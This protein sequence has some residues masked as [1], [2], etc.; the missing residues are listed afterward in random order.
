MPARR[1]LQCGSIYFIVYC[2]LGGNAAVAQLPPAKVRFPVRLDVSGPAVVP[3]TSRYD[4]TSNC[5]VDADWTIGAPG[6][7]TT[8]KAKKLT[9]TWG[10]G[11][12]QTTIDVVCGKLTKKIPVDVVEVEIDK[13]VVV[14][15]GRASVRV[16]PPLKVVDTDGSTAAIKFTVDVTVTGPTRSPQWGGKIT[17]GFVQRLITAE[18]KQWTAEYSLAKKQSSLHADTVADPPPKADCVGA[19][20][21]C[22]SWYSS[23]NS[24]IYA[25]T[26]NVAP[27]KISIN[28][29]PAPGWWLKDQKKTGLLLREAHA[30]WQ[31][32]TY[33]CVKSEDKFAQDIFFRRAVA[34]W[35]IEV[36]LDSA[37]Q[38]TATVTPNPVQLVSDVSDDPS[39]CAPPPGA[40]VN[41]WLNDI[42]TFK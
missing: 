7:P 35:Q 4:Y 38:A 39:K 31:F 28:D 30:S 23:L 24:S 33:V 42:V 15:G 40:G 32:E 36:G 19:A 2:V 17:T 37:T 8:A 9:I 16:D 41:H 26:A 21:T 20:Q 29:S 34:A 25:P 5:P 10:G 22:P 6:S 1:K 14:L 13:A 11:P 12:A 27:R 18:T 3:A